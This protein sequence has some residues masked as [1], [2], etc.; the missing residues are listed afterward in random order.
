MKNVDS[1]KINFVPV[2]LFA[3]RGKRVRENCSGDEVV[4]K[5]G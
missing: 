3:I 1:C 2:H 5:G 4:T